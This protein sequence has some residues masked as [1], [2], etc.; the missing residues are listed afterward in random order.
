MNKNKFR[1]VFNKLRGLMMAVAETAKNHSSDATDGPSKLT[2]M[3]LT[4]RLIALSL[5]VMSGQVMLTTNAMADIIADPSAPASQRPV[6]TETANGLP[7]VNIQTP[8]AAGVSRNTYRQFN[9]KS[10]GAILNNSNTNVQIQLGGW[11][12][13]NPYLA[14]GTAKVILNEVNSQNPSQL[15][16][17]IEVAGSRAQVVIANPAGISCD[18]CGFINANRATLT[19]GT[20]IVSS[21]NL[22]GYRVGGGTV[23]FL[24]SGLDTSQTNFTDVIARAV[25][26]N[27]GIWANALSIT[28]GT[29]Q[30]NIDSDGKQ[31]GATPIAPDAGST[32]PAF[33]VDVAALGGMYA[34]KIHMIGTEAGLGVRN[35]GT[36]GAGVGEINITAD[37]MLQNTGTL[38]A[39]THIQ[40]D[41]VALES[42][43]S[44]KSDGNIT[45]KLASDYTHTGE[46]QAGGD[47]DLQTSDDITNQSS[48][49]ASQ[50]LKLTAQNIENTAASEIAGNET[51]I[52]AADTL[53][54][55]GLIDGVDTFINADTLTNTETGSIFG[56]HLAI[57]IAHLG[58]SAGAVIAARDRLD[59]GAA[60]IENRSDGLLFSAGDLAIDG[61]LDESYA[62]TG[63]ADSLINENATIEALGNATIA[64]IDSQNLNA[65]L[66]TALV[67]DSTQRIREVQPEGWSQRYDISRFPTINNYGIE[68]QPFLN[69]NGNIAA[70]FEDYTYYDY[71]ATTRSTH[72][73][74]SLPGRILAGGNMSLLGNVTNSD[75]QIIAGGNLDVSGA[76]LQNLSTPGQQIISYNG[77]RQF[78]DWDGDDEELE[79]G[80][81]VPFS[82][83]SKVTAI[84][85]AISQLEGNTVPTGSGTSIA[86]VSTPAITGS[87]FQPSPDI[88]ANYLI[89]TNPRFANYRTWLSSDYMLAQLSFDPA[90]TQKR[91]GDGFYEQR[92]IR[93]QIAQLTGRRFLDSHASD[94][95]QY[96]A[97]MDAGVTVANT[98]QLIPG[99]ALTAEQIA[100]L[101]SDIVW[102]VEETV[103]LPDGTTTQAL[104]PKV[105]VRL[106]A[107]DL[108]PTIGL[109]AGNQVTMDITGDLPDEG[110]SANCP[111]LCGD[112]GAI[113][114]SGTIAGRTLLALNA[115]NIQNLGGQMQ[116][117]VLN[118]TAGNNIDIQ[119]GV[120]AAR[121]ALVLQAGN[122]MTVAS[123]TVDAEN[124]IGASTFSRTNIERVAGLYVTGDNGV[125]VASA[126]NDINLLAAQ[127][128]NAGQNG[129]T[130]VDA[131]NNLNLGTVTIAEQN[132]SIH[133]AKDFNRSGYTQEAGTVIQTQGDIALN[134]GNNVIARAAEVTSEAGTL[135]ATA[136][137]DIRIESGTATYNSDIGWATNRSGTFS[138]RKKEQRDT[139]EDKTNISSTLSADTISLQAGQDIAI[140]PAGGI[141]T[142]VSQ[143]SG[144]ISVT[145]SNVVS[146]SN[147]LMQAT[148]DISITSATNT[149]SETHYQKTKRSGIST[150]GASVSIGSQQLMTN[151]DST[152]TTQTSSTMGSVS[153]DVVIEAGKT[154]TQK[155]SDVLAPQGDIDIT[156]QQVNIVAA[157]NTGKTVQETKFKQSGL[158]LA[159]SNPVINA[160]QTA[161]QMKQAAGNTSDSRMQALAAG[162]TA[163]AAKNAYDAIKL[164]DQYGNMPT[165]GNTGPDD[166][167]N[168][169]EANMADQVGGVNLSISIGSSKS[170]STSTQ[171]STAAQGS[172]VVAGGDINITATGAG[173]NSDINV[174]G[175]QIKADNNITLKAEDQIN[176]I[177]AKN[178]ETLDS[179]NKSSSAS[180]GASIGTSS[181]LVVTASAS[182]GKGKASGNDVTW[183]ETQLQAGNAVT[184]ESG[185]DTNLIGAQVSGEQVVAEVGTSGSGNLNIQ[186]LQDTST[187]DSKQKSAGISV[188]VPI[189]AGSY[190]GS[191]SASQSKIN[192]DYASVNEQAGIFAGDEGFQ[193]SVN[194][195]TNLKG[196]VIASTEQA[197]QDGKNNL[198]TETLTVSNIQNKAEYD[199]KGSSA[200]I[201][202]GLQA[203]LPQLSGAGV[204]SDGDK[205][206]STTVSAVSGGEIDITD[207]AGQQAKSGKDASMTVAMLNRDVH[208][209][210]HGN[211]VDSAGNSTANSIAPIFDAEKVAKEI[212]AQVR[213]TEAFGQQA[214]QAVETYVQTQRTALQT[215][216]KNAT[217]DAEKAA[218]KAQM[219][220]I[221]TQERVMNI[222]IGAVTG[223]GTTAI[224]KES[225]SVAADQFRQIMIEDSKK[226]SGVT[227]G[228]T[229]LT[230]T[231]GESDGVRGDGEKIGGTRVDLDKLCGPSNERCAKNPDGSLALDAQNRVVWT[232]SISLADFLETDKGK[233]AAG[234]TGG[235]QG[236]KGTLFGSPYEAGSWQDKLIEAFSGT[237]DFVG[238]KLSGLYDEQGN[239]TRGR[240]EELQ[241]LQDA[242][243]ASGAIVVST[244]F[245]MAEFLPLQVWQAISVLLKG[246]K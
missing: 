239:A 232:A 91:L 3:M 233:E 160:V 56:D 142:D 237:H 210:E 47:L 175:S 76:T 99:V 206:S 185:T 64:V 36:L 238:G 37:G 78:R 28:T 7:L 17:F 62:S 201:G 51:E 70:Y 123:T 132:N 84:N 6:I 183:T 113:T 169:R 214:G 54:N 240:S 168:V 200:T 5:L 22:L 147:T 155:G 182:K 212:E 165:A 60:S 4:L 219:D 203:G 207:D 67:V 18:G 16:G 109:M 12:Q 187:Y 196:A 149:H 130:V 195:N 137:N 29:N 25:E 117:N 197:I 202:G 39:K 105:Y 163:L 10:Q 40:I 21:G 172:Q 111:P 48:M 68:A 86:S 42:P 31:T 102:L 115:D 74:S 215:Q 108:H 176:L 189:G 153:G 27:A 161:E 199:A 126:G 100:Q 89:E 15:N 179:K 140:L 164:P 24:G 242:W 131:G 52:H 167:V 122:D 171:T 53:T 49:L 186:S 23:R 178:T 92:L 245:A 71:T 135:A 81:W 225:L 220:D 129:I 114:N 208:V 151:T 20:P 162:T 148:G 120:L 157:Q 35:A 150:S 224:T 191:I 181:G 44:I 106:Q 45:I 110:I 221:T 156:A 241:K 154:Y 88:T 43:G 228:T 227:D 98:W 158:T 128:I 55:R 193:V 87:L 217:T 85:L 8:S 138:S 146:D 194:G 230:N 223:Q 119:G 173:K 94:E 134:A 80:P 50:S 2:S 65:G 127:V 211:A 112:L 218:I 145:G 72:V 95:A 96:Q 104:V 133:S 93:E 121:D 184:L 235:I 58:N 79:F 82:P 166:L 234:A 139:F 19:T 83:S 136:G 231:S 1:V 152:Y 236:W 30:V 209:D 190:G 33:A 107:E 192:S 46:L 34:G 66:A 103:T 38:N 144:N 57:Q 226:F 141:P 11:V 204:G 73:V 77:E 143:K 198:T 222:L 177:A 69:E 244:P 14:A 125:L 243:S 97:L 174:I 205:A 59:I 61:S 229:V 32:P 124:R 116:A 63:S 75:S 213:I 26:V 180:V 9:V 159:I 188:S 41:T 170:S 101:T 216:L 246:A 90:T 118:A 13:G